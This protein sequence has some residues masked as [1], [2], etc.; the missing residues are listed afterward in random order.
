MTDDKLPRRPRTVC[1]SRPDLAATMR[2]GIK[3][4]P[5][6]HQKHMSLTG[7]N[8]NPPPVSAPTKMSE[9]P[10]WHRSLHES[11]LIEHVRR[12]PGTIIRGIMQPTVSAAST[13]RLATNLVA[14]PNGAMHRGR[15]SR[16]RHG[17]T[18]PRQRRRTTSDILIAVTGPGFRSRTSPQPHDDRHQDRRQRQT[19]EPAA[20]EPVSP[21]FH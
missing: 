19:N 18:V 14:R 16:R 11:R 5:R 8:I 17:P 1:P 4:Q 12:S 10:G 9:R 21:R 20:R 7:V 2:A 15:R 13:I 3:S 6:H